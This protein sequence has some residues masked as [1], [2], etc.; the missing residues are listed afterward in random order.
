[1]QA[2]YYCTI[3]AILAIVQSWYTCKESK[4]PELWFSS[5]KQLQKMN[6]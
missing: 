2:N 6:Y 4:G 3:Q 5:N 1:M